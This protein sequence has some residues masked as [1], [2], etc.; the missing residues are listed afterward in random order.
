MYYCSQV[1]SKEDLPPNLLMWTSVSS[2]SGLANGL[3][4][5]NLGLRDTWFAENEQAQ[6]QEKKV[7]SINFETSLLFKVTISNWAD[8]QTSPDA[9]D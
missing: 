3:K 6:A 1:S 4:Y 8:A 2:W 5:S 7:R 9:K